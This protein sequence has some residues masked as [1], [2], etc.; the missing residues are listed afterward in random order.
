MIRT[1]MLAATLIAV[2]MASPAPAEPEF[3]ADR[4][5]AHVTFLADDLLEGRE[6]GTRGY[7]IAA[8]Y[9]AAQFAALGVKP[10]GE[11]GGYF[12]TVDL[13]EASLTEAKPAVVVTSPRGTHTL[14]HAEAV[15]LGGPAAGGS[16]KLKAPLVFVG[17]GM[18]D[19][20]VGYDDY[21][22]LD[23]RGKIAVV[24]RGSPKGM[25]SEIGAHLQSEQARVAAAHGAAAM[26]AVQTRASAGA[27]PWPKVVEYFGEPQTA[28]VRKDGTPFD[29]RHGLQAS[30]LIEPQAAAALFDGM[31]RTLSQ[32]LDEADTP[33]GR[34]K[35]AALKSTAEITVATSVRR[36]TSP[37]VI[38]RIEGSDPALEDEYVVLMGHADHIGMKAEGSGDRIN[39][40]A[41]DNGAGVA[42]LIEVARALTAAA[43]RPRRSVLVVAH[44][45]EE[46]GLLGA[47]YF[48]H[49]PPVPIERITAAINL[50]MPMLL[51]EFT[52]VVAFGAGRSSLEGALRRAGAAMRVTL[53]PDPMPEQAIFVR[54]DHYPMVKAGVPSVMVATGMANGG[55]AGWSKF[56]GSRYHQPSDDL[57]QPIVWSA[58][59]R[60]AEL[61][62]RV[63]RELADADVPARWYT[64]DYFGDR[65]APKAEKVV[66]PAAVGITKDPQG[67]WFT[68]GDAKVL[69]YQA[70]RKAMPDGQAARSNYFHP[71]YDLDGNVLTEDF[72]KDHIHHRGIFWAW[73][74][75]RIN[76]ASVQDQW[77]NRDSFWTVRDAAMASDDHSASLML[78]VAWES[79]S[80]TDGKGQ[81]RPFVEER[82]VTR[83]HRAAQ[84]IRKI[85]FHQ[86]LT[87]LVDG[88]E[89][90]GSEDAKGYGGF[91]Y[92][93]V[94]PPDI[95]FT[96]A[97]GVVTPTENAVGA[98]PWM[99]VSG[100]FGGSGKSG[101]T[102]LTHPS[103]TGF[104]QP[105]I[106]RARGSMQ[107][108]VYPGR[109]AVAIPRDRPVIL[110]YRIVLHRGELAAA[111][112]GRLQAEYA[113]ETI[114]Q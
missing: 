81:R 27:I 65:F 15:M 39:N 45:A 67:Y 92:R 10:G 36:Y 5:K 89:I 37:E 66:K 31:P 44:T 72:P 86:Q 58:A 60:F 105:W 21:E 95:R 91:S 97:Q 73:H 90:G 55:D 68:D 98:S 113:G 50:D 84:G 61:N 38:G 78:R 33:G 48:A 13:L 3:N 52:D 18:K 34:P 30:G 41:L 101:L 59:A 9:I 42:T 28:W 76:G 110:R 109:Q 112:I 107:N 77:V 24:L 79:P 17:F 70:E 100:T 75:V 114:P 35:G 57:S 7:D 64:H 94:M 1:M 93:V 51:Y 46:K 12:Q 4:I 19:A 111:D 96:G 71:L 99:D 87:A 108:A 47:E 26:L 49:Y 40:G 106:L 85:D 2:A 63:I 20:T 8:R 69:F 43:E 23:V 56:L 22:G 53:S 80:F 29:P 16:I 104:P 11:K 62:Y 6:A 25:D 83:V 102:V 88:V 14:K 82:S 54:S 103:T 74:Q 32:I